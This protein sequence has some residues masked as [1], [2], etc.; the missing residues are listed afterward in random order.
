MRGEELKPGFKKTTLNTI[1]GK[2]SVKTTS[3]VKTEAIPEDIYTVSIPALNRSQCIV[4]DTLALSF[5]F[6]NS[7]AKSWFLN[8]LGRILVDRLSIFVQCVEV[9]QSTGES[10]MEVYK[11][12]WRSKEDR[13]KRKEYGLVN[14]NVR[15]LISKDDSENRN[16]KTD[17]ILDLTIANM[18]DRM[19]IPLGKILCDHGPYAPYGMF[20][21][22]YRI[23]LPK[24]ETILA[25]QS[26]QE[27]GKYKL[28][29]LN[30]EYEIIESEDLARGVKE[31]YTTGRSL[32]YDYTTLLQTLAW[33]K[34]S[35]RETIAVNIPRK[36]LKAI[37]LLFTESDANDSEHFPFPNLTKVDV[38]VEGNPNDLYSGG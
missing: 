14:E 10:M 28:T 18:F 4:P 24:S 7:N 15:K 37:V 35:E 34:Y 12:L 22:E 6:S 20:D 16:S 17:G 25:A 1:K 33:K 5:K 13:E 27:K 23:T 3:L 30:L 21:F 31:K 38:T 26:G 36:S 9:Y 2:R 11:D 19:K 32:G 29:D 8:N